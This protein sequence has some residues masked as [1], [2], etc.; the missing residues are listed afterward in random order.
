MEVKVKVRECPI[1]EVEEEELRIHLIDKHTIVDLVNYLYV[2]SP[3]KEVSKIA[4][5]KS[6]EDD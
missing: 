4:S 6:P 5:L 1:C 2:T 3:E